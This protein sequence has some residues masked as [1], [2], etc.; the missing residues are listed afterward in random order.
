MRWIPLLVVLVISIV[1]GLSII[2]TT[3]NFENRRFYLLSLVYLTFLG[4][5]LFTPISFDGTAVYV[6]PAGIG[7]VNLHQLE[8]FEIGFAENIIL[9]VPLGFLIKRFFAQI[10][11]IS[12]MLLGLVIGG[13][14]ETMQYFLSHIFLI[15]RTSDI[16]DVIAN[17]SGIVI[18]AIL[19]I[20][21]EYIIN[22][23][24]KTA[25]VSNK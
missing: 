3:E 24:S 2:M 18:G 10:S 9:T 6:M 23:S 15:N 22:R 12:T 20:V 16:N 7:S 17:A 13:G 11:L 1:S 5:I 25:N 14:I 19:L 4:T 21:Y 8:I